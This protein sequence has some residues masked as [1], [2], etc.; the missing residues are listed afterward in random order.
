M[1]KKNCK[2]KEWKSGKNNVEY[3]VDCH[4][5]FPCNRNCVHV[6]CIEVREKLPRCEVCGLEVNKGEVYFVNVGRD[7]GPACAACIKIENSDA[8]TERASK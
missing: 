4:A 6:D 2:H 7:L 8:E 5:E 1:S 3:C